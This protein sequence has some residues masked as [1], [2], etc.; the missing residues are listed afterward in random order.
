MELRQALEGQDDLVVLYVMAERQ[1]NAKTRAFVDDLALRDRVRFL[2][3]ADGAVIRS[4]GLRLE[5]PEPIEQ[6]VPHPATY[7]LDREGLVRM[8]DVRRDFHLW[9][10]GGFVMEQ[11]AAIP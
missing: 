8:V 11:L 1:I 4:Y 3:D 5:S 9:L 6:G 7:L 10:D 2:V